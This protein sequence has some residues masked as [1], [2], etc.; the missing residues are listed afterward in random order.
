MAQFRIKSTTE[1]QLA[2]VSGS[3][4]KLLGKERNNI[5]SKVRAIS[6]TRSSVASKNHRYLNYFKSG[7]LVMKDASQ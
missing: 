4:G 1:T 6:F 3:L 5:K 7:P 2:Y